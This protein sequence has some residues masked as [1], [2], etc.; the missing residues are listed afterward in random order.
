MRGRAK[1]LR[2]ATDSDG[3]ALLGVAGEDLAPTALPE[4]RP[5]RSS[6]ISVVA[7]H[8]GESARDDPLQV[9]AHVLS[10]QGRPLGSGSLALLARSPMDASGRRTLL[11]SFTP[12]GLAPGRYSLRIFL[13]DAVTGQAAHA[14]APFLLQ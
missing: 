8:F 9:G 14:S 10:E 12:Q 3:S 5:G 7:Y 13:Q 4:V 11:L 2:G 6:P 1:R